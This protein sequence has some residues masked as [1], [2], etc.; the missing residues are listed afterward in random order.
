MEYQSGD[1]RTNG[2]DRLSRSARGFGERHSPDGKTG[3]AID[4]H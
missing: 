4:Q 1:P 3:A 2:F